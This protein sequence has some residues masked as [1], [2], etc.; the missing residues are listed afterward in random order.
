MVLDHTSALPRP[1]RGL[2]F[3]ISYAMKNTK[4]TKLLASYHN[5]RQAGSLGGVTSFARTLID[6]CE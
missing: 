3:E 2:H 6:D 4:T 1:H 5:P